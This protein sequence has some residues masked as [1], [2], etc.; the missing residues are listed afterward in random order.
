M[1]RTPAYVSVKDL[2][3]CSGVPFIKDHLTE[4]AKKRIKTME[5]LSPIISDTIASYQTIKH[6]KENAST[7]NVIGY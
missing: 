2:H 4:H 6:I 7:L 3:D 1:L 5:R